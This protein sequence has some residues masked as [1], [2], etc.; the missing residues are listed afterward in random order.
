MPAFRITNISNITTQSRG[1]F[2]D[3]GVD[4]G[5]KHIGVGQSITVQADR[6][7]LLP[8]CLADW[9][10]RGLV[11]II[12]LDETSADLSSFSTVGD[13][14]TPSTINPIREMKSADINEDEDDLDLSEA[15][16]A[17]LPELSRPM[18]QRAAESFS[19]KTKISGVL[20]DVTTTAKDLSPLFGEKAT[21]TDNFSKYTIKA[22]RSKHQ[23]GIVRSK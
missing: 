3:M 20:E 19:P 6:S 8:P 23:G 10:N 4:N 21:E 18:D 7:E 5:G 2:L 14:L 17:A 9:Q 12:N 15:Q 11:R 13:G 16:E 22:P 1:F